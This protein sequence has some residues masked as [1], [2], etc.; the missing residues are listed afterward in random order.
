M[1]GLREM[2]MFVRVVEG[3]S[4]QFAWSIGCLT[5]MPVSPSRNGALLAFWLAVANSLFCHWSK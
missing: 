3:G 5:M 2:E 1:G 4:S